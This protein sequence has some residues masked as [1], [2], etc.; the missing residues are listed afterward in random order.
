[1]RS[2]HR[3]PPPGQ[4]PWPVADGHGHG[5]TREAFLAGVLVGLAALCWHGHL[6]ALERDLTA[7]IVQPPGSIGFSIGRALSFLGYGPVVGGFAT[8]LAF[9]MWRRTHDIAVALVAPF[10]AAL[11]G[12]AQLAGKHLVGRVR[13]LT[14][15]LAGESGLG[16]PS[17]HT[18]AVTAVTVTAATFIALR[19]G[20][21]R[22]TLATTVA[23][24]LSFAVA[25]GRVLVGAHYLFD[26]LGGLVLGALCARLAI[27]VMLV[28]GHRTGSARRRA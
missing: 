6:T 23:W 27:H 7:A 13:P 18:T 21:R 25:V 19:S 8:C 24:S 3:V 28:L 14:A 22:T 16:F 11:G 1:M 4:G 15:V 5:R 17:G 20:K 10:A 26:V 2:R 9:A 12:V